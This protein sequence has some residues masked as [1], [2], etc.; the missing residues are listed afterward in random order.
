MSFRVLYFLAPHNHIV[1]GKK[2]YGQLGSQPRCS[3]RRR[4]RCSARRRLQV[5]LDAC[6]WC[7]TTATGGS[8]R[9][10]FSA[11]LQRW[12]EQHASSARIGRQQQQGMAIG[13][14]EC[15][16]NFISFF[17]MVGWGA[18]LAHHF[19]RTVDVVLRGYSGYNTRWALKII[20]KVFPAADHGEAPL[21][22]TVFFGANDA[23]LPG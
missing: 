2:K 5:I 1:E 8:R 3:S 19:S 10:D 18:S 23:C 21:A 15:W 16:V 13:V 4:R 20:E 7:S 6:C 22:V 12:S 11:T 17:S 9:L 14:H